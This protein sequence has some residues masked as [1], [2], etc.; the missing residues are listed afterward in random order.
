MELGQS[1][2][3]ETN[4]GLRIKE[5]QGHESSI[6][7]QAELEHVA[8]AEEVMVPSIQ[9]QVPSPPL[10]HKATIR[11]RNT[12]LALIHLCQSPKSSP[13]HPIISVSLPTSASSISSQITIQ[14]QQQSTQHRNTPKPHYNHQSLKP[15]QHTARA[16]QSQLCICQDCRHCY[17]EWWTQSQS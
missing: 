17:R 13:S 12:K 10:K 5:D 16:S 1:L 14:N 15:N 11:T 9:Y 2:S 6:T 4:G 8:W 3:T 7:C